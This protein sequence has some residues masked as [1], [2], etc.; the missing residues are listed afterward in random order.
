MAAT[1]PNLTIGAGDLVCL[2][3][4]L[5]PMPDLAIRGA[6]NS[7]KEGAYRCQWF[8]CQGA[9]VLQAYLL[10]KHAGRFHADLY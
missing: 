7:F 2:V 9:G 6:L 8:A 4:L 10:E 5:I 1:F 3:T